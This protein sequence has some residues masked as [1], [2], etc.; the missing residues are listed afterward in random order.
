M[1]M[2]LVLKVLENVIETLVWNHC[3]LKMMHE[4]SCVGEYGERD[5]TG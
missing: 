4:N 1:R 3:E 5:V 2:M